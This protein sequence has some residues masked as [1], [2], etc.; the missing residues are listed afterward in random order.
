MQEMGDGWCE[1]W[2]HYTAL[3]R[4]YHK[5]INAAPENLEPE[6][7]ETHASWRNYAW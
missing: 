6:C 7:L 5:L 2:A 4:C 3:V 1:L